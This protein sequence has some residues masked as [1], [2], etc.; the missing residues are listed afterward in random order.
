M[1]RFHI[2]CL[3][4]GLLC[5]PAPGVAQDPD[6]YVGD[7]HRADD[8]L[9]KGR[10]SKARRGY[11]EILDAFAEEPIEDR[12]GK[13]AVRGA[14][15]GLLQL[16]LIGGDY[17]EVIAGVDSRPPTERALPRL[18]LYWARAAIRLGRYE[19]AAARLE[20]LSQGGPGSYQARY[21]R[22]LALRQA[23]KVQEA[24]QVFNAAIEAATRESLREP[25]ALW[26]LAR[27][28]M[29][30]GGQQN[31]I[32]A[33]SYLQ[34][35]FRLAPERPEPRIAYG[36]LVFRAYRESAGRPHA[37]TYIKKVLEQNGDV[38][39]ALLVLYRARSF[40]MFLDASK[41]QPL[42][43]RALA[44][45]PRSVEALMERGKR[46][47]DDRLFE[48]GARVLDQA[49]Q[50]N[51]RHRATLAHRAAAALLTHD[52]EAYAQLRQRAMAGHPKYPELDRIIGD[53]LVALYRFQASVSYY[54]ASLK[55]DPSHVPSL[56]GLAKAM[57]YTSR[58]EQART[59][60]LKAQELEP[61]FADSWR[62]NIL[63]S[64]KRI[65]EEYEILKTDNFAFALHKDD[66]EVLAPYLPRW[67]QDAYEF[68]G[69]KYGLRPEQPVRVEVLHTW[70]DFSVRTIGFTGFSALGACFGN[71]VTM[72]SPVDDVLRRNDFMWSATAWHE[73]AHV[74]TLALS[75][76]RVPRWLTEGMSV[77]E[78]SSK[79]ASWERGMVRELL[80]AY[81]NK[82]LPPLRLLNRQFR[83]SS[84]LFGYYQGGLAVSY[85]SEKH[86]FGKV[87]ELLKK[88]GEDRP[89]E[90][91]FRETFGYSTRT[92]DGRFREWVY[93]KH[94]DGLK[95]VPRYS[96][97]AVDRLKAAVLVDPKAI[98]PRLA[99]AWSFL[100][101]QLPVDAGIHLV[102]V[103]RQQRQHPMG[104]LIQ[105]ELLR[106]R[107]Q[108]QAAMDAFAAGFK[109]GADDFESRLRYGEM[110]EKAGQLD[111]A[112]RQYHAAKACWPLC[113]EQQLS[114]LL[115][116]GRVLRKQGK[117]EAAMMELKAFCKITARAFEPRMQLAAYERKLGNRASE[118][119]YLEE[120]IQID[121]FMSSLHEQLGDAYVALKRQAEA[122]REYQVALAVRPEMDRAYIDTPPPQRPTADSEQ[123]R[124]AR[125]KLA[126]KAARL[127][128]QLGSK[129]SALNLLDRAVA[130]APD[131]EV[132]DEAAELRAVWTK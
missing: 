50:I 71:F 26:A 11:E 112:L 92:F 68:L 122:L 12:P 82:E 99:L 55:L 5:L 52:Q 57:V 86:G 103:L 94:L 51:P 117:Q 8:A 93:E 9:L 17:E 19:D 130:Y 125:G 129:D 10:L 49:L 105:A 24:I 128:H 95:L 124:L 75:K 119:G 100:Q 4:S 63:L 41:T 61:G 20:K 64:Q 2:A 46:L 67:F 3:F 89:Q 108:A 96:S 40:N 73:Y 66:L 42:L 113:S 85:L 84:I 78:E 69:R 126:L 48:A 106:Q 123:V 38:E 81:H 53:H 14:H 98:E 59:L 60:L 37:E 58:G 72:V 70:A 6:P 33:S 127:A 35:A 132:S 80:D 43:E 107:K 39:Q 18:H 102:V 79:N 111:E 23:G 22:G 45:N 29:E 116:I 56:H 87:V 13:E 7:L 25:M 114:P 121:P 32:P 54:N 76:S 101:R 109:A 83:G 36:E 34:E 118:A 28:H 1:L 44:V 16:Q 115:R 110:L 97:R 120:C 91:I 104:L 21:F 131:T 47:I 62:K 77:Y 65:E 74:L 31:F 27:C 30:L 15:A 88:Y 90:V